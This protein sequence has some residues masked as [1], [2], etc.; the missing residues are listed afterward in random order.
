[1]GPMLVIDVQPAYASAFG[2]WFT[3]EVLD[4]M[5]KV[6]AD[7]PLVIVSVN[8][9]LSGDTSEGIRDFWERE[10]MEDEL[11]KRAIFLEKPYA[12]F[13]GWMD[14][15]V[16]HDEIVTVAKELRR[17]RKYD[18]RQLPVDVLSELAPAGFDLADPLFLPYE[19]E[20]ES[21]YRQPTWSICGGGRDECLKEVELWLHSCSIAYNRLD[22]L[23]Y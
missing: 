11:F 20:V 1:M 21:H 22:H 23:T 12:F 4:Q 6:P 9:E 15:G 7:Q 3:N 13:R 17:R 8:E 19:L 14:C 5:R 18:S 10:G 16:P 2:K